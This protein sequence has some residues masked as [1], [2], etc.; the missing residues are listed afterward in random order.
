[1]RDNYAKYYGTAKALKDRA[2]R[3]AARRLMIKK[4]KAKVWDGK[5]IDHKKWL[6]GWNW[7]SNLRSISRIRNRLDGQRKAMKWRTHTYNTK[8][9]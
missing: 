7:M 6:A 9:T 2:Q 8:S 4:W 5:E 1:M 3:N